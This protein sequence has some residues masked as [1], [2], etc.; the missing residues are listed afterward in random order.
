[1]A[2]SSHPSQHT[3]AGLAPEQVFSLLGNQ[4]R[5]DIVLA[6]WDA[7]AHHEYD[8]IIDA[9][10]TMSFSELRRSVGMRD[11]GR[12]N[13]H[14]SK[15]VPEL[16]RHSDDGYRLSGAGRLI[17]RSVL[18]VNGQGVS[19]GSELLDMPC[20]V[21]GETLR[22]TYEDQWLSVKCSVCQGLF[23]E[24]VPDGTIYH[25][26]FPAAGLDEHTADNALQT[27]IYRCMLDMT[28]LMRK[29]C[30]DCASPTIASLDYCQDHDATDGG[31]CST[32]ESRYE[33][34]GDIRCDTCRLAKRLPIEV[35]VMALTPVIS[36]CYERGYDLLSPTIMELESVETMFETTVTHDPTQVSVS[37][38]EEDDRIVITLDDELRPI[39]IEQPT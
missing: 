25:A 23:G 37:I 17:I 30:R 27:G 13:Y 3:F 32:C 1:M 14:L 22:A 21:C 26:P 20:P 16:V 39:G 35:C 36:F 9:V 8:D 29:I 19:D 4:T 15:L 38:G 18:A 24:V 6:L 33:V 7:R 11:K 2:E 5:I 31:V 12:F 28:Y 34:W 10:N